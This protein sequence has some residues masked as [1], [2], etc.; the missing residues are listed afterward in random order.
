MLSLS[1]D[2]S[3]RYLTLVLAKNSKVIASVSYEAWQKQSEFTMAELE[4]LF[5]QAQLTLSDVE[6][7]GVTIGPGSYTGIRIALTIAKVIATQ[8][9]I[10]LV[11][12]SSLQLLASAKGECYTIT[13]ARAER[14]FVGHYTDSVAI[15]PDQIMPLSELAL[16]IKDCAVFGDRHL[17]GLPELPID[18]VSRMVELTET[19]EPVE[20]PHVVVPQY[21]KDF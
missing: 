19:L 3:Y 12:I 16:L 6:R 14:A 13:D 17:V 8:L 5:K 2:T 9:H 10:P 11:T 1:L 7:I 15:E 21:L 18:R 4:K 20:N